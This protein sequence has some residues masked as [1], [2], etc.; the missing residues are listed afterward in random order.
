MKQKRNPTVYD[1]FMK[2]AT[3]KEKTA[4]PGGRQR[5]SVMMSF[6]RHTS[7]GLIILLGLFRVKLTYT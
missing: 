3:K 7:K 2:K 4:N 1:I 6:I 5:S